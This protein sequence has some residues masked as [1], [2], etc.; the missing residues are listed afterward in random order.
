MIKILLT[1]ITLP[2]KFYNYREAIK[3]PKIF[4]TGCVLVIVLICVV[5]FV[6]TFLPKNQSSSNSNT[7]SN[8][9]TDK[10]NG[11]SSSVSLYPCLKKAQDSVEK[12]PGMYTKLAV[13]SEKSLDWGVLY[14]DNGVRSFNLA[15]FKDY[16]KE[17]TNQIHFSQKRDDGAEYLTYPT[18]LQVC[19]ES[20]MTVLSGD[21]PDINVNHWLS[22]GSK[23]KSLSSTTEVGWTLAPETTGNYRVD[24]YIFYEGKWRLTDRMSIQFN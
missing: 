23:S 6:A 16:S 11:S 12:V 20:N 22:S 17:Q 19:S 24:A 4:V 9:I 2:S 8:A 3:K 1:I 15:S 21:I 10:V 13:S 14:T 7:P 5:F 18:S